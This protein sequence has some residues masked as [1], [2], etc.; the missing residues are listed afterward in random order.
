MKLSRVQ[1][2]GFALALV[3]IVALQVG[4]NLLTCWTAETKASVW[5]AIGTLFLAVVT[6]ASVWETR[7]VVRAEDRRQQVSLAPYLTVTLKRQI[8]EGNAFWNECV[9]HN[10]GQGLARDVEVEWTYFVYRAESDEERTEIIARLEGE[11]ARAYT[12]VTACSVVAENANVTCSL[13]DE[14]EPFGV[15]TTST[16]FI[17]C[18]ITYKGLFGSKYEMR[19]EDW[20]RQI[21]KWRPPAKLHL[22]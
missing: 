19:Y 6:A 5:V 15:L 21:T 18:S 16:Y 3:T 22:E 17:S 20:Y 13:G 1:L 12:D 11:R 2:G 9:V 7:L 8:V 4:M 14:A 10:A